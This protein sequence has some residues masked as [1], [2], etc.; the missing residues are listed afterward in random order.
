MQYAGESSPGGSFR[1]HSRLSKRFP[2][3]LLQAGQ[4]DVRLPVFHDD[5]EVPV[6]IE[7]A[8]I[9]QFKFGLAL[10]PPAVFLH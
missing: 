9:E 2:L 5:V 7:N 6:L 8:R 4:T 1:K 10:V 3:L